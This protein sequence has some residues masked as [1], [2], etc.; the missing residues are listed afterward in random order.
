FYGSFEGFHEL[1]ASSQ[2]CHS[3]RT[4]PRAGHNAQDR[5]CTSTREGSY[6]MTNMAHA[7]Q[8]ARVDFI[9]IFTYHA[10]VFKTS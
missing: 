5:L 8:T 1:K 6:G 4:F 7:T 10:R 9:T 2:Y 3:E